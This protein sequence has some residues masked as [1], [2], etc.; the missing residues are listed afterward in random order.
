MNRYIFIGILVYVRH[1]IFLGLVET[2]EKVFSVI[3][4]FLNFRKLS[5][6]GG[7]HLKPFFSLSSESNESRD[8]NQIENQ[9]I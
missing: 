9:T 1:F 8:G 5:F 3:P 2:F 4:S 6:G 7:G